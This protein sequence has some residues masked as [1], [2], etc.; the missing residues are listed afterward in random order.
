MPRA[1]RISRA[2]AKRSASI[3]RMCE[4]GTF[5]RA[6]LQKSQVALQEFV[7]EMLHSAGPPLRISRS[8]SHVFEMA[9][10]MDNDNQSLQPRLPSAISVRSLERLDRRLQ[11]N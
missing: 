7:T 10:F 9:A 1:K 8:M 3:Q 11:T 5:P 4:D 6:K 2:K